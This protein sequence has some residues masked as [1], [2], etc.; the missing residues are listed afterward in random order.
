MKFNLP[1]PLTRAPRPSHSR[2]RCCR[3]GALIVWLAFFLVFAL[4][5][6]ALSVDTGYM[7]LARTELQRSVDAGSLAGAG[8]LMDGE[9]S[10]HS[11]VVAM[12]AKNLVGGREVTPGEVEA[13]K[14]KWDDESRSFV[15]SD[16]SPNAVRVVANLQDRPLFFGAILGE[17]TFGV[18]S[19]AIAVFQP[20]DVLVVLDYSGSMNDDSELKHISQLGR[21]AIEANLLEIYQDLGSP[22][23]GNLQWR[24]Q[25]VATTSTSKIKKMLGVDRVRYPYP[26]GSWDDYISYIKSSSYIRNAGY[27]KRYGYLTLVNYWL[28]KRPKYSQTPDLWQTREQPITAVKNAVSVFLAYIQEV[29]SDDQ[30]GLSVYTY[31]DGSARLEHGLTQDMQ[32]VEDISRQRQAGHYH[33]MTN[34]GA[35]LQ[36]ARL[37]LENNSRHGAYKMIVLM[38]DGIANR[39]TN[40][41]VARNFLLQEAQKCADN[42]YNVLTV[43]LGSNADMNLM[44][45]VAD[46]TGGIHFNIPGG[47]SVAEYE[48]D[49]EDVFR[50]IAAH[51]PLRLVN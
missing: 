19:D 27:E 34:I 51:R 12:M 39:P 11:Q 31:T 9:D 43:S 41:T 32:I 50:E 16:D 2:H 49:L 40:T 6:C 13:I 29:E 35:G 42:K 45:Q 5:L 18:H 25:Y 3:R 8:A 22:Q 14:G 4:S 10:V 7:Y 15:P 33:T 36:K 21:S 38:T 44:Q 46:I 17:E 1:F 26:S 23:F 24:P 37:E 48:N 28:E 47:Q 20:R 30:V